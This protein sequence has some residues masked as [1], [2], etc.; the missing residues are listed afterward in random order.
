V[1]NCT[2]YK[3]IMFSIEVIHSEFADGTDQNQYVGRAK[4]SF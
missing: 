1:V 3:G 4:S 2:V